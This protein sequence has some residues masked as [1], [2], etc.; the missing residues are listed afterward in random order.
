MWVV[1]SA[2]DSIKSW[3]CL[4]EQQLCWFLLVQF[5]QVTTRLQVITVGCA[6]HQLKIIV[7]P[8]CVAQNMQVFV[9]TL[10]AAHLLA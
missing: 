7:S 1:A 3:G 5:W 8:A 10:P 6:L 9:M 2:C 4:A